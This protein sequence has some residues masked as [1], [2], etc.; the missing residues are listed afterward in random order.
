MKKKK[1]EKKREAANSTMLHELLIKKK[2]RLNRIAD[3]VDCKPFEIGDTYF[4]EVSKLL[5]E[6]LEMV[7]SYFFKY[8]FSGI[9]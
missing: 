3:L 9:L 4:I 5:N 8:Y 7:W 2:L 6:V 1:K